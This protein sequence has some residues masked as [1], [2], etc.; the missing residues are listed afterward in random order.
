MSV[1]RRQAILNTIVTYV[2]VGLGAFNTLFLYPRALPTDEIGL[3]RLLVSVSMVLLQFSS[4]GMMTAIPRFFPHYQTAD[5]RHRAFVSWVIVFCTGGLLFTLSLV[6][7]FQDAVLARFGRSPLLAEYYVY[8]LP[9]TVFNLV[10][11]VTENLAAMTYRTVFTA[12]LREVILR[13][14]TTVGLLAVWFGWIDFGVFLVWFLAIN[15]LVATASILFIASTGNFK[16]NF[17][18]SELPRADR[19]RILGYGG[20]L[21]LSGAT[22]VVAQSLDSLMLASYTG[23][24]MVGVFTTFGFMGTFIS[25]PARALTRITRPVVSHAWAAGDHT[26]AQD[27]YAKSTLIQLLTCGILYL[28]I[29]VN[30]ESIFLVLPRVGFEEHFLIFVFIGLGLLV[31]SAC[32]LNTVLISISNKY[33]FDFLFNVLLVTIGAA[34]NAWLIPTMGGEGAALATLITLCSLNVLKWAF[35]WWAMNLQPFRWAHLLALGLL[36]TCF[37]AG[38]ALPQIPNQW[39]DLV[40]R[41]S[42][43]SAVFILGLRITNVSPELNQRLEVYWHKALKL[44]RLAK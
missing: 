14:F 42:L 25:I 12:F 15:G 8:L 21:F 18:L 44:L 1:I 37:S 27:L 9:L 7:V 11:G 43:T 34:T 23:L 31:D 3:V 29:V 5:G 10:V 22:L 16:L 41:T 36:L 32:G 28:G 4:I 20:F 39:L 30:R 17:Q 24:A 40:L 26:K 38:W 33:R 13:L 35:V 19:L 2:G 6:W